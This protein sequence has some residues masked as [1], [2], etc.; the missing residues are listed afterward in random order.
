M[1]TQT[2]KFR[3]WNPSTNSWVWG[4]EA[5]ITEIPLLNLHK[6]YSEDEIKN[7]IITQYTGVQDKYEEDF[8]IGDIGQFFNGDKFVIRREDHL[9]FYIEWICEPLFEDQCNELYKICNAVKI[10]NIFETPHLLR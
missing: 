7:F 6:M 4:I 1:K 3:A 9:G 5:D 10:G 2:H 8:Y